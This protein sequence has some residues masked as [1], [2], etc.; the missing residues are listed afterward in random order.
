MANKVTTEWE[1]I[2]V[3]LGNYDPRMVEKP[4]AE[5]TKEGI[6]K[7]QSHDPFEDKDKDS[8]DS[9]EDEFEDDFLKGYMEKRMQELKQESA[10]RKYGSVLEINREE[11]VHQINE[12]EKD[13]LVV[14]HLY[15]EYEEKCKLMEQKLKE[16]AVKYAEVKLIKIIST[17]AIEDFPD[18]SL[19]C[20]ILYFNGKS[21]QTMP[22]CSF[23]VLEIVIRD[24]L[25]KE[26]PKDEELEK[27]QKAY[28]GN[29]SKIDRDMDDIADREYLAKM[30]KF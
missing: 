17:K 14:I 24:I 23:E 20:I 16:A 26:K 3:K 18:V 9:L 27:Y 25:N 30:N 8:L 21:I 28:I 22:N 15:Q 5:Y 12:A 11:W 2:H 1:D 7:I 6:E 4:Q 10:K 19:P 29:K 13:V